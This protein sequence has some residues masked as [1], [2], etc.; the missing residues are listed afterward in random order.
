MPLPVNVP[1]TVA[2][3]FEGRK[4]NADN[5]GSVRVRPWYW[6][7]WAVSMTVALYGGWTFGTVKPPSPS[8][9]A[10]TVPPSL[11]MSTVSPAMGWP[12]SST[13][14]PFTVSIVWPTAT[15]TCAVA[16]LIP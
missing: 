4:T 10:V 15:V 7:A 16:V 12:F 1:D 8:V 9:T 2:V 11:T 6:T 5:E 3:R 14:I 13:T